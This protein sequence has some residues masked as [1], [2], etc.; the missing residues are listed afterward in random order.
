MSARHAR[1]QL[2]HLLYIAV[3]LATLA[4]HSMMAPARPRRLTPGDGVTVTASEPVEALHP[5]RSCGLGPR[6]Y[7]PPD[8][9]GAWKE[10][11]LGFALNKSSVHMCHVSLFRTSAAL[12][13]AAV[14]NSCVYTLTVGGHAVPARVGVV[15]DGQSRIFTHFALALT[16]ADGAVTGAALRQSRAVPYDA[17][18]VAYTYSATW[19][20]GAPRTPPAPRAW[21][22]LFN[23]AVLLCAL[24]RLLDQPTGGARKRPSAQTTLALAAGAGA[25]ALPVLVLPEQGACAV[26]LGAPLCGMASATLAPRGAT[27][28][29]VLAIGVPASVP[30]LRALPPRSVLACVTL[31]ALAFW[32]ETLRRAPATARGGGACT[33]L[34]ALAP[35]CALAP[36]AHSAAQALWT[37]RAGGVPP[38]GVAACVAVLAATGVCT[39]GVDSGFMCGALG[40]LYA[41]LYAL[42][43]CVVLGGAMP[44]ALTPGAAARVLLQVVAGCGSVCAL[45]AHAVHARA[46][47]RAEQV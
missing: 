28:R 35:G 39:G 37:H 20:T 5:A 36:Y 47:R 33:A 30:L 18:D 38:E 11:E 46:G 16:H 41:A 21:G 9:R 42:V 29:A 12:V 7:C 32:A 4:A 31:G 22:A 25:H 13:G 14:R 15:L 2:A 34:L 27:L 19:T 10:L 17:G 43:T 26:A 1:R 40:A 45:S 44:P 23:A 3:A 24:A 8:A 6:P